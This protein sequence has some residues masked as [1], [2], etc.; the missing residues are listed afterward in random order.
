LAKPLGLAPD[1]VAST[2]A[3][4]LQRQHRLIAMGSEVTLKFMPFSPDPF[5]HPPLSP[6]LL[7]RQPYSVTTFLSAPAVLLRSPHNLILQSS[8]FLVVFVFETLA[9]AFP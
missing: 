7:A 9:M 3:I 8:P 4:V 1:S 6:S 5:S 2:R